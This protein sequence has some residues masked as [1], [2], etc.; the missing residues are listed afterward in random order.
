[1]RYFFLFVGLFL[2]AAGGAMLFVRP[3]EPTPMELLAFQFIF[4]GFILLGISQIL[5]TLQNRD[6]NA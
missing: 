2:S 4:G 1:M 3:G 5:K 6:P